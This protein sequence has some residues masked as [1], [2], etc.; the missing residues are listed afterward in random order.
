MFSCT[1]YG[2]VWK[3]GNQYFFIPTVSAYFKIIVKEIYILFTILNVFLAV[4]NL[5]EKKSDLKLSV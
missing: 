2:R 3:K 1:V 5:V 4:T